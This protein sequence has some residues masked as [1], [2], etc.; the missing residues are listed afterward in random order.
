[1]RL[2]GRKSSWAGLRLRLSSG[3]DRQHGATH[4]RSPFP[5]ELCIGAL[6]RWG[7]SGPLP[8]SLAPSIKLRTNLRCWGHNPAG[9]SRLLGLARNRLRVTCHAR[10]C[11]PLPGPGVC[12]LS[13]CAEHCVPSQGPLMTPACPGHTWQRLHSPGDAE[14]PSCARGAAVLLASSR[15]RWLLCVSPEHPVSHP[16]VVTG[17]PSSPSSSLCTWPARGQ[18][19]LMGLL[20]PGS[21]CTSGPRV[22]G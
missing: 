10:S 12:G 2:H 3:I 9:I 8:A 16:Q 7:R 18:V 6:V 11:G 22:L 21:P 1:M 17:Q 5:A 4:P 13:V 15:S 19:W 20:S 14:S